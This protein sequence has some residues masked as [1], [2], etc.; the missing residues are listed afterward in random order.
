MSDITRSNDEVAAVRASSAPA[1]HKQTDDGITYINAV[2]QPFS[3]G[4]C[5]VHCVSAL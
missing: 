1:T 3:V 2:L 4:D 5:I